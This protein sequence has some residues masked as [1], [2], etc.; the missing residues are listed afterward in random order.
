MEGF[1]QQAR[2][3]DLAASALALLLPLAAACGGS[4]GSSGTAPG[5]SCASTAAAAARSCTAAVSR[6]LGDCYVA[7]GAACAPTNGS[8]AQAIDAVEGDVL[9]A[10]RDDAS[11]SEAGF[12]E[13]LTRGSLVARLQASCRAE[14]A[15]LAARSFGGPHAAALAAADGAGRSCLETAHT[16][17]ARLMDEVAGLRESCLAEGATA[18]SCS[19]ATLAGEIAGRAA[20]ARADLD[21]ACPALAELVAVDGPTFV[22]RALAQA[23]CAAA[24]AYGNA[25]DLGLGCGPRAA[26]EAPPRGEYVQVVLDEAVWG[27]RC[28]DGSPFAFWVRLAPEGRPVENVVVGMQGGGVCVFENDCANRDPDLFEAL[29][30]PPMDSGPLSNDPA[31][32]PLA[33]YTKVFLPYCT[34]DVFIGGGATSDFPSITV[35]RFGAVDVRAA[36]RWLRDAIWRELDR[37]TPEGYRP[38]R[39][40]TYFG[41]F[42]AGGFGTLYNYHYVLDDLQWAHTVAYPDAALALDS[43][44]NI[45]VAALGALLVSDAPPL[46]WSSR[47]YLPPYCFETDCGVGPR[48]LATSAPRLEAVPEQQFLILSNQNDLTQVNTTFFD[49]TPSWINAMRRSYCETRGLRGVHYFLTPITESVHVISAKN[50]LYTGTAVD[51]EIMRDW[52]ARG[53]N[54]PAGVADRVAEG[55]LV[56]AIPGVEPFPCPVAP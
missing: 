46:G 3:F 14:A 53:I 39:M 35:H 33:D 56:E 45:S 51:G 5:A 29:S 28:G 26:V 6:A 41:G 17:G 49:S 8:I 34:Q 16:V 44:A 23:D 11:V 54:D 47:S 52:L 20:A 18:Q 12:G 24:A 30:D 40:R 10:C 42:S 31:V 48:I 21:A 9:S 13:L 55:N 32:N 2:R 43:G 50:Q 27:T 4:S 7:D 22:D 36:L 15:S 38:D 37:T 25:G 19:N 1:V